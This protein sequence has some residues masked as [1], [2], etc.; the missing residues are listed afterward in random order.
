MNDPTQLSIYQFRAVLGATGGVLFIAF[1][2]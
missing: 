1:E 2:D